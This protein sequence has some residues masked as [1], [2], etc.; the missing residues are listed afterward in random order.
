MS[1]ND[2]R[3]KLFDQQNHHGSW[4][5]PPWERS[6]REEVQEIIERY[7]QVDR[8]TTVKVT[9]AALVVGVLVGALLWKIFKRE[10]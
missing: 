1:T 6:P 10:K 2:P 8:E 9:V 7:K 4:T 5:R 3:A